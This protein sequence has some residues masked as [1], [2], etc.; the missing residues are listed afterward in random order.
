MF[1]SSQQA[2]RAEGG[3]RRR[4]SQIRGLTLLRPFIKV[5][6]TPKTQEVMKIKMKGDKQARSYKGWGRSAAR[7]QIGGGGNEGTNGTQMSAC[8]AENFVK[9]GCIWNFEN[10]EELRK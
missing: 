6:T 8:W 5:M 1:C 2:E 4:I 10:W 3:Q 7:I 9:T